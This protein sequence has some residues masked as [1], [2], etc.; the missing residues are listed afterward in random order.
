MRTRLRQHCGHWSGVIHLV[1]STLQRE[2]VALQ[3]RSALCNACFG[4]KPSFSP[5]RTLATGEAIISAFRRGLQ[6]LR[7]EDEDTVAF[8]ERRRG[9]YLEQIEVLRDEVFALQSAAQTEALD[10]V[11]AEAEEALD[12][13]WWTS[14]LR[15]ARHAFANALGR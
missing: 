13:S 12:A 8:A 2:R 5:A 15:F 4:D 7:G 6:P 11:I 14:E 1:G 10:E 3:T 9:A